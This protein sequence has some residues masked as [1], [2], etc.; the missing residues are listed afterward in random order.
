M[1]GLIIFSST[2]GNT[3]SMSQTVQEALEANG[4]ET[5]IK[6]VIE[7][8]VGELNG[9]HDIVL[10]GCP[11]YGDDEIE[12]QEDFEEFYEKMDGKKLDG[13]KFA[14]FAPGD[15]SYEHFCGSVDLLEEKIEELGGMIVE[16][17]LKIDGD[18]DDAIDEIMKWGASVAKRV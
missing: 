10:L 13:K 12:L 3:E 16:S 11:S 14:V 17:G 4:I 2:T 7:A 9:E 6:N 1:K 8:S 15:S 18:P 5:K